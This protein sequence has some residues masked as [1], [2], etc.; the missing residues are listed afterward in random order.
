MESVVIWLYGNPLLRY[1][2]GEVDVASLGDVLGAEVRDPEH[3]LNADLRITPSLTI[4]Y[5]GFNTRVIPFDDPRA[6]RALALAVDPAALEINLAPPVGFLPPGMPGF[7]EDLEPIPFDPVEAKRLWDEA[8]ADTDDFEGVRF[9]VFG[10]FVSPENEAIAAMWQEHLGIETEFVGT[11]TNDIRG[12]I[13]ESGAHVFEYGWVADYPDP[14]NFLDVLFH[15]RS[16]NNTGRYTNAAVD[17]LLERARVEQDPD[18]RFA[19]Y[20]EA[21]RLM[22]ED[23]AAIPLGYHSDYVLVKSY[24]SGWYLSAQ[25]SWYMTE[26]ELDKPT[27]V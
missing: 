10:S 17:R 22:L 3:P 27:D 6:R 18:D 25:D 20:E 13:A 12:A 7:S 5:V 4:F 14:E 8:L 16:V 21:N 23:T 11:A 2:A 26:V 15:S 24:V 19:L 1:Q 9:Q